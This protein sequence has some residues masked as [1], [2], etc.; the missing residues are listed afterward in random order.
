MT[1]STPDVVAV[2][3][4]PGVW[5]ACK[6]EPSGWSLVT[7]IV[8]ARDGLVVYA[9]TRG[10]SDA[11]HE[12]IS[13]LGRPR[14]L[15]APNHFH[16]LGIPEWHVRYPDAAVVAS[17]LALP[18]LKRRQASVPWQS[19]DQVDWPTTL[20]HVEPTGTSNGELWLRPDAATWIVGDAFMNIAPPFAG[21]K[22]MALRLAGV[23]PGLRIARTWRPLHLKDRR[24]YR[25]WLANELREAPPR[26]LV[27]I[28]GDV[29]DED[30]VPARLS[31][32]AA[33]V[34]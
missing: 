1:T 17:A 19:V 27:P 25:D 22:G 5:R 30:D 9:P 18:R 16:H 12:K 31:A 24:T 14:L 29:L 4:V 15:V 21:A 8:A 33:G 13:A 10:L 34:L 23:G 28:H 6:R 20:R 3:G 7:V 32:L 11:L 26:R 2:A